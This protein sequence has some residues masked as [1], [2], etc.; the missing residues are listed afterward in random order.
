MPLGGP[1]SEIRWYPIDPCYVFHGVNAYRDGDR[2]VL[3]V[4][5]LP[6]FFDPAQQ[7]FAGKLTLRRWTVDTVKGTVR[8]DVVRGYTTPGYNDGKSPGLFYLGAGLDA[9]VFTARDHNLFFAVRDGACPSVGFAAEACA[10][11]GFEHEPP[12]VSAESDLDAFGFGLDPGSP[13]LGAGVALPDLT[14][15]YDDAPRGDPPSLGAFEGGSPT[16]F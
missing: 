11:P 16:T 15:D 3:D 6:S 12:Q 5:R 4:C 7:G 14:V 1:A 2:I 13:A 9:S 8:D 10:D